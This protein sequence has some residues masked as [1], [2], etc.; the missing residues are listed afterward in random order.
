MLTSSLPFPSRSAHAPPCAH[1][2]ARAGACRGGSSCRRIYQGRACCASAIPRPL[3][4]PATNSCD[5]HQHQR[6]AQA[7]ARR[8]RGASPVLGRGSAAG[9]PALRAAARV[10]AGGEH[11]WSRPLLG[12]QGPRPAGLACAGTH[13]RAHD[14]VRARRAVAAASPGEEWW[15]RRARL[16]ALTSGLPSTSAAAWCLPTGSRGSS[17]RGTTAR[18]GTWRDD[19]NLT[20][21]TTLLVGQSLG[22][23]LKTPP[24]PIAEEIESRKSHP[25]FPASCR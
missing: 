8:A 16:Y 11:G 24:P 22:A 17:R 12:P 20:C 19:L 10:T 15:W 18:C 2:L 21:V 7:T 14:A 13:G 5:L 9:R 25:S 23:L 1:M 4:P 3:S 6:P